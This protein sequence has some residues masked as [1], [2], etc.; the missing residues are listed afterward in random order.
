MRFGI[1]DILFD[2]GILISGFLAALGNLFVVLT[3]SFGFI[4]LV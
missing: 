4:L 2:A 3:F 1:K